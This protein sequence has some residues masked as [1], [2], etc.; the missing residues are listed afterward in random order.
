MNQVELIHTSADGG[1]LGLVR[2]SSGLEPA[3]LDDGRGEDGHAGEGDAREFDR[4][5]HHHRSRSLVGRG[6]V[7][8][9][10]GRMPRRSQ[11][12]NGE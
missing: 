2:V 11:G 6:F 3:C 12:A 7:W 4:R 10:G 1:G 8:R 5:H 9:E